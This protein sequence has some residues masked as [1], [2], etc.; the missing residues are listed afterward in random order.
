MR[1]AKRNPPNPAVTGAGAESIHP[2]SR[3][4]YTAMRPDD[5]LE[6]LRDIQG[7]VSSISAAVDRLD[8]T[9]RRLIGGAR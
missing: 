8:R 7:V 1:A 2:K 6:V 4:H 5:A 3:R 9:A